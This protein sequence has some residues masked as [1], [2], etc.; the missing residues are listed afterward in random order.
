MKKD[1]LLIKNYM[2]IESKEEVGGENNTVIRKDKLGN[3]LDGLILKGYEKKFS[4]KANENGEIFE[5]GCLDKFI[6]EY[7]INNNLN[8]VVDVLHDYKDVAGR[9]LSIE[10]NSVGFWFEVYIPRNYKNYTYLRDFLL[11][12]GILQG[13]SGYGYASQ[14]EWVG[15]NVK[16]SEYQMLRISLVDSPANRVGF[17]NLIEVKNKLEYVNKLNENNEQKKF[18]ELFK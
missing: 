18:S 16:I 8:M 2:L 3:V 17:E 5:P 4:S 13:F 7:F 10:V 12:E 9:V 14:Y 15:N 6:N 1:N 11:A